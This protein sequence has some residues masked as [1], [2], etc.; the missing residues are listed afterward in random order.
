MS[1]L[2]QRPVTP[3]VGRFI[4]LC[5][6]KC[7]T[8]EGSFFC[9]CSSAAAGRSRTPDL[10]HPTTET[11]PTK[12]KLVR[13]PRV[14]QCV[15]S[16]FT[17]ELTYLAFV[18]FVL[19]ITNIEAF[20]INGRAWVPEIVMIFWVCLWCE[21]IMLMTY[22][23]LYQLGLKKLYPPFPTIEKVNEVQRFQ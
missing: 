12:L 16:F 2:T 19:W 21:L 8:G 4:Y 5:F 7:G 20:M 23:S 3:W 17:T 1:A 14:G 15:I 18:T 11:L 10:Q 6:G 13:L 22:W 9:T